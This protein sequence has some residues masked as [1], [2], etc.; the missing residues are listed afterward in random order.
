MIPACCTRT[1]VISQEI[2]LRK[3]IAQLSF[4]GIINHFYTV[5]LKTK[6][7]N[8]IKLLI[9][10]SWFFIFFSKHGV[11]TVRDN[12]LSVHALSVSAVAR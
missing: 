4:S 9:A 8:D 11:I 7:R 2:A 6:L 12:A 1:R 3:I 5:H 10:D